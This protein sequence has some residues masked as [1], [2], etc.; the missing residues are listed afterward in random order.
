MIFLLK[1]RT[2]VNKG[3]SDSP[4]KFLFVTFLCKLRNL[5]KLLFLSNNKI[6]LPMSGHDHI[7]LIFLKDRLTKCT[8]HFPFSYFLLPF[9][10]PTK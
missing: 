2:L 8:F 4:S 5:Q 10:N 1:V 7:R 9:T 6:I 3:Y